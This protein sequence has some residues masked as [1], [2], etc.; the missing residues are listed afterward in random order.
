MNA[1]VSTLLAVA[2]PRGAIYRLAPLLKKRDKLG[3]DALAVVGD[4]ANPDGD[5]S[6]EY[7]TLFEALGASGVPSFWVPGPA[8]APIETYLREARNMEV[9]FPNLR[10]VHGTCAL[11]RHILFAGLGGEIDDDPDV[12]RDEQTR[13]R[14]PAWHAEYHLKLVAELEEYQRVLLFSTPPAHKGLGEPGSQVLAELVNTY[15]PRVVVTAGSGRSSELLGNTLVVSPGSLAAGEYAVVDLRERQAT[16]Y[17]L[18]EPV[19]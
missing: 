4:L 17:T 2:D 12:A 13:L 14:Y 19:R 9:V 6:E 18:E 3:F 7:R 16:A 10:G 8:D 15:R 11:T 5:R 1:D